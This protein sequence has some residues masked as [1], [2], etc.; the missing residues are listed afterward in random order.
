MMSKR[1]NIR[2][3]CYD[4]GACPLPDVTWSD[5]DYSLADASQIFRLRIQ[6]AGK[7]DTE[8][9]GHPA[10]SLVL[11]GLGYRDQLTAMVLEQ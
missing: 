5:P 3:S 6:Q 7:L 9:N 8:W 1:P 10:G 2:A 11:V 4:I